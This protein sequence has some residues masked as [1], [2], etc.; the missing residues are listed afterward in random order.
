MKTA[1]IKIIGTRPFWFHALP[2]EGFGDK[3]KE[4]TGTAGNDPEEWRKTYRAN[5]DG[6]LFMP[7]EMIFGC[8]RNAAKHTK[9]GRGSIM[10][11]V[12]ATLQVTDSQI[13]FDRS[14]PK[15]DPPMNELDKDVYLDVR[16]V[17]N[18]S[19]R[20]A[21]IRYRVALSPGWKATLN[22]NGMKQSSQRMR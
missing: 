19:T 12:A 8:L 15:D 11:I 4:K 13:L 3:R 6:Q 14:M 7:P 2:I 17:R 20:G 10:K 5:E 21:N 18:P 1:E 9:K 22:L 16:G